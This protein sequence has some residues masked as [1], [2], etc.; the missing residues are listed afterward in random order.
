MI[1][2][3]QGRSRARL[4]VPSCQRFLGFS[5]QDFCSNLSMS[6]QAVVTQVKVFWNVVGTQGDGSVASSAV[7]LHAESWGLKKLLSYTLRRIKMKHNSC[8]L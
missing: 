7:Q 3:P 6:K 1:A 8:V 2:R 5:N 4:S